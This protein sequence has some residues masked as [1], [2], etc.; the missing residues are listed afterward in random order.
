MSI[1]YLL[2]EEEKNKVR[3]LLEDLELNVL[4]T[5]LEKTWLE[6]S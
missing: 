1:N 4:V 3:E 2:T 6:Q 5:E